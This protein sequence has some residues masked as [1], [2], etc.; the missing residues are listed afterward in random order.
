MSSD[1]LFPVV[2]YGLNCCGFSPIVVRCAECQRA[3][4]LNG[5]L[6]DFDGPGVSTSGHGQSYN[7]ESAPPLPAPVTNMAEGWP[8][9]MVTL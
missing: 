7:Q 4:Q 8:A 2:D 5:T 3:L 1:R 6:L 9:M